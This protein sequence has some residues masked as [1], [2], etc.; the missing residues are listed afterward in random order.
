[1]EKN[2]ELISAATHR[3]LE[4]IAFREM[5]HDVIGIACEIALK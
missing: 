4:M 2:T 5:P 3:E 1:M